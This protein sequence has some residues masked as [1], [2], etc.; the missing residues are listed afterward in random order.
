MNRFF[1]PR[2][3]AFSLVFATVIAGHGQ[4]VQYF[5]ALAKEAYDGKDYEAFYKNISE[6]LKLHPFHQGIL[7]Q[8]GLACALTG[9]DA[10]AIAA[11]RTT[12][13]IDTRFDLLHADLNSLQSLD[14][15]NELLQLQKDLQKQVTN[16]DTAFVFKDKGAHIES[17]AYDPV[18]KSFF[19]SS[20]N[21]RKILKYHQSGNI[22]DFIDRGEYG[23]TAV[24]GLRTDLS[25]GV[26]WACASPVP[27]MEN[28]DSTLKSAVYKFDLK[29]GKLINKYESPST[30]STVFG[31]LVLNGIGEVFV[32]DGRSNTIFKVNEATHQLE[33]FFSAQEFWNMQG[34]AFSKDDRYLFI[35]DYIKGIYRLEIS[36]MHLIKLPI[37][38]NHSLK[39]VDGLLF[40]QNSL[41]AVHNGTYP[42]RLMRYHLSDDNSKIIR[43]EVIDSAHPAFNEP[44]IACI[45]DS[46]LYY[47]ANSQWSAYD[48]Q[49]RYKPD[50]AQDIVILKNLLKK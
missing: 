24:F 45:A 2:L 19:L 31:D 35:A 28:Y 6:A 42:H 41:I 16:S 36:T 13:C 27:E 46:T 44:T 43:S 48:D 33:V 26:L 4:D 15:F 17:V 11:L 21:Q 32:S 47:V 3:I 10:G 50:Q 49:H 12:I 18:S 25:K 30:V 38:I 39:G 5:Y 14:S 29:T 40:Y 23:M 20:I 8:K 34:I 7:Y 1:H 22:T 37:P 9:R